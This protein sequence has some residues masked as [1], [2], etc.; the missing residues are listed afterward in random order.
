MQAAYAA[1]RP[2]TGATATLAHHL[3]RWL[4]DVAKQ[5]LS[6]HSLRVYEIAAGH[7]VRHCGNVQL[8]AVR[9]SHFQQA[10]AALAAE[11]LAP[12]TIAQAHTVV[13]SALDDAVR[14]A[15]I[16][17][18]PAALASPPRQR[19]HEIRAL[20]A[21]EVVAL[22]AAVE[23]ERLGIMIRLLV[24]TGLRFGEAAALRWSDVDLSKAQLVVRRNLSW[25]PGGGYEF[26]EPKTASSRR[27]VY[28]APSTVQ[29]LRD[30]RRRQAEEPLRSAHDL[31][32]TTETGTPLSTN[33][34]RTPLRR[35]L[36]AAGLP[37]IRIHDLRHT[38]ASLL[39]NQ[40]VHPNVVQQLLGHANVAITMGVYA[41]VLPAMH[42]DAVTLMERIVAESGAER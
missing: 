10:Y 13:R 5:R 18:N 23:E 6:P 12:A 9:A 36:R 27:T 3:A 31:V 14:W 22:L 38:A 20:A 33:S 35:G 41:H 15:L 19:P 11:G 32:F 1:A 37:P 30:H 2:V 7:L 21:H 34:L 8:G 28:L 25:L 24:T 17:S 39:L 26:R 40:G 29:A 16:P 42:R 4:A